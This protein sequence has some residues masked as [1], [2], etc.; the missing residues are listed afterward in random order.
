MLY[1][2]PPIIRISSNIL[3]KY[4]RKKFNTKNSIYVISDFVINFMLLSALQ[5]DITRVYSSKR[6]P[7]LQQNLDLISVIIKSI[8]K[9][10]YKDIDPIIAKEFTELSSNLKISISNYIY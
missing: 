2:M 1:S 9:D 10:N 5:I 4:L 3:F 7:N 6:S 8:V